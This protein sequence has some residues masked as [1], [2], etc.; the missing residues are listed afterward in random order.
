MVPSSH[1]ASIGIGSVR[2]MLEA[3]QDLV[4]ILILTGLLL[5][6]VQLLLR[7]LTTFV[8]SHSPPK[9]FT[10]LSLGTSNSGL[11]ARCAFSLSL[12]SCYA[13]LEHG[14][15]SAEGREGTSGIQTHTWISRDR[16]RIF[17]WRGHGDHGGACRKT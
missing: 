13:H 17:P 14:V 4:N 16:A 11:V 10:N 6:L 1:Y 2:G 3:E 12:A 9:H 8:A 15:V 7:I 5:F